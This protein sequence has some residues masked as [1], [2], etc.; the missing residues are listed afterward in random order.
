M[1]NILL[2]GGTGFIGSHTAVE[3]LKTDQYNITIIDDLSNSKENVI[4]KIKQITNKEVKFIKLDLLDIDKLT[5][6]FKENNFDWVIHFAGYKAVGESVS[7]PLMY[8]QNNLISTMN[9]LKVMG[10]NNCYNLIFSSSA[11]VYGTS[12][13]PLDEISLTGMGISNPYGRTKNM[14]ESMLFDLSNSDPKWCIYSLRY[15]NPVGADESGLIGEDP[16]GIPNNLMPFILKVAVQN[17][18]NKFIDSKYNFLSV[19]GNDYNTLD[20]TGVRDYIHVTDLALGHIACIKKKNN[21]KGYHVFNLGSGNGYSVLQMIKTFENVNDVRI[22]YE[23]ENRRLGDLAE[24][25]CNPTKADLVL[26]WKTE[27]TLTD[28]CRDSWNF[29]RNN[30]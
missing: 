30:F 27:K 6:V 4:D 9:L 1:Q 2:T 26:N 21:N 14:I 29:I 15:F 18:L 16:K 17:N 11:T 8:Y 28:I 25:Y 24:T 23:F 12:P 19:F 13:P 7:N 22:P 20:G 3:L 5:Q 10:E